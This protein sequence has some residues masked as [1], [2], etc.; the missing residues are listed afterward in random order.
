MST[1]V[2]TPV[3]RVDGPA[4]VTGTARYAAEFDLPNLAY[5]AI[6]SST[7]AAGRIAEIDAAEAEQAPG[8]ITVLHHGNA[9]RLPYRARD[10]RP[11]VDPATGR[12]LRVFQDDGIVFSGQPVAVV[13]ADTPERAT[14]AADLVRVRYEAAEARNQFD[15]ERGRQP[16][17]PN[18]ER[19]QADDAIAAAAAS[20]DARYVQAREH[21]NAIEP[22]ATIAAW[23]GENLTLYDK[24]QWVMNARAAI[25]HVFGIDE[26]KI[27]VVSPYVGGAFGS[28]L[29][30]WPH[31][32]VAALAA[33]AAGR[34]VRVELSRREL[35]TSTGFRPHTEQ[36]VAL[37]ADRDGRLTGIVHEAWGQTSTYEDYTEP[38]LEP[39]QNTYACANVRTGY[40]LVEMNTNTP[41]PMRAPG[42]I[43]GLLALES[44]M[45]ELAVT[46]GMDPLALRLRNMAEFD[47]KKDLPWS[48][49]ELRACYETAAARFGWAKRR[50]DP[51]SMR[52][53][54]L[55]VGWGM[56]T[57]IYHAQRSPAS[58]SATIYA[59]G[60]AV[61]RSAASDMGPGT[62][63]SMT[64]IAAESLDLPI[65]QVRFELGDTDFPNAP[66]HGGSI[67]MA[68]VGNGVA[69]AC[70]ALK[71]RL[72]D[73]G[74]KTEPGPDGD[75]AT[76]TYAEILRRNNMESLDA[77]EQASP[78]KEAETHASSAFG[79]VFAEVLVDPDLGTIRVP[80]MVGAYDVGRVINPKIA[81]SQCIG[82]L[83]GGLGMALLEEAEWD[84]RFGRVMNAN[85][86]EYLVPVSADIRELDVTFVPSDDRTFN[87]LGAKGLAE[88]AICGV[89]PAIANAVYHATGKRIREFPITPE[90]ILA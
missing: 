24:T 4:K 77:T 16:N 28:A 63:T 85:L 87:P 19:G 81:H 23:E 20:V 89:A 66:V 64:Q 80:R 35:Y 12:E 47:Q 60:T 88:V 54:R 82:G 75:G 67:T 55:R 26:A 83:V 27:H 52:Q 8:V 13:V 6:V 15:V 33:R 69:A 59:N 53:G 84:P 42:V 32:T 74:R 25:A 50:S 71:N 65:E 1:I 30:V 73:L 5:G 45:D 86:A 39:P 70:R 2:G 3:S 62:Y 43:T 56:A 48:S 58:A 68:S 79:A 36:R 57:A 14:H 44:A 34:P 41:C 78:G 90:R 21:H 18:A 9:P 11:P 38:T 76:L 51:G 31:V 46:L 7:V 49:N 72:A 61:I 22:H 40:E 10:P 29:R 37:G 17:K